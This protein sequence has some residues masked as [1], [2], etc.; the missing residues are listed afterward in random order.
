MK[1]VFQ[2][3]HYIYTQ[4]LHVEYEL[5]K[6]FTDCKNLKGNR[7]LPFDFYLPYY[8]LCIEYDG[9]HHYNSNTIWGGD[10]FLNK[11]I[12][13]DKI[14]NDYCNFNKI[15]LFRISYKDKGKIENKLN[16][17]FQLN[18]FAI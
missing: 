5:E 17:Y 15:K 2:I 6:R 16:E 13:H 3:S 14:K 12:I 7:I 9:E 4:P 1:S 18:N 11:M 10:E 8:N